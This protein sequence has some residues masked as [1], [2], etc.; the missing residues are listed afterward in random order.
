M[1]TIRVTLPDNT[2]FNVDANGFAT[3]ATLNSMLR[4]LDSS[5]KSEKSTVRVQQ[6]NAQATGDVTSAMLDL[7]PTI[8][9]TADGF[10]KTGSFAKKA[11]AALESFASFADQSTQALAAMSFSGNDSHGKLSQLSQMAGRVS[12]SLAKISDGIPIVSQIARGG[13]AIVQ[14]VGLVT[15]FVTSTLDSLRESQRSLYS[16]GVFFSKGIDEAADLAG[17]SGTTLGYLSKAASDS[18]DALR[19]SNGGAA[20]AL[21]KTTRA[22][23]ML[24]QKVKEGSIAQVEQLYTLGYTQDEIL[25]GIAKFNATLDLSGQ[26]MSTED[27]ANASL[28][29]LTTMKE[30]DRITGSDVESRKALANQLNNELAYRQLLRKLTPEQAAAA[31]A[32]VQALNQLSPALGNAYKLMLEGSQSTDK[33]IQAMLSNMPEFAGI[34]EDTKQGILAGT[35]S[36][37]DIPDIMQKAAEAAR[38]G[39]DNFSDALGGPAMLGYLEQSSTIL[40]SITDILGPAYNQFDQAAKAS[41]GVGSSAAEIATNAGQLSRTISSYTA[42]EIE[43]SGIMQQTAIG[44]TDSVI[45]LGK[46]LGAAF[47]ELL[48]KLGYGQTGFDPKAE[49]LAKAEEDLER[50]KILTKIINDINEQGQSIAVSEDGL[51]PPKADLM[52]NEEIMKKF[53][54]MRQ[55]PEAFGLGS[56]PMTTYVP[57]DGSSKPLQ[58][59]TSPTDLLPPKAEVSPTSYED[60]EDQAEVLITL[61]SHK[62]LAAESVKK[63]DQLIV[64]TNRMATAMERS[65]TIAKQ[66]GYASA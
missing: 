48:A 44:I 58:V 25:S 61:T 46:Q 62:E 6:Q 10:V 38:D 1:P 29:Y 51:S 36:V 54:I 59:P 65:N 53:G 27:L 31:E 50:V 28:S 33:S 3:E 21:T 35:I 43:I 45:S 32:S 17:Q 41:A 4:I 22:F 9:L 57:I 63:L 2:T 49:A 11:G 40:K 39:I 42:L 14:G 55:V 24:T 64:S 34:L 5:R 60:N 19:R 26:T 20:V 66:N 23:G 7:V 18:S 13:D 30:L 47:N 16:S 12:E 52:L 8:N 56:L 15:Q 37:D